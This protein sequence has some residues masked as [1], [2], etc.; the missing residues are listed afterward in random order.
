MKL[1]RPD[2]HEFLHETITT[3]DL[4]GVTVE[5]RVTY[6]KN[7]AIAYNPIQRA[8]VIINRDGEEALIRIEV[9]DKWE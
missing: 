4:N 5:V 2:E 1:D 7:I 3:L 8:F 9:V 6:G